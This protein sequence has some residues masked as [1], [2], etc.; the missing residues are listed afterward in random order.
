[1]KFEIRIK[2][3]AASI[4][5]ICFLTTSCNNKNAYDEV[6]SRYVSGPT[7]TQVGPFVGYS[8]SSWGKMKTISEE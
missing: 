4:F 7:I 8:L 2:K 3:I 1:M 5:T 6:E